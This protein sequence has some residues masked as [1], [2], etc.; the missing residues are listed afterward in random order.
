MP[1]QEILNNALVQIEKADPNLIAP[2]H[3]SIIKKGLISPI[4]KMLKGLDCGLFKFS[5]DSNV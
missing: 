2:Q 4:I 5:G 3:G 1:S